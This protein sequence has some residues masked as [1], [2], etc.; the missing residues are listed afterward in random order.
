[1]ALFKSNKNKKIKLKKT[2]FSNDIQKL[3]KK[4]KTANNNYFN[5]L[6]NKLYASDITPSLVELI[7]KKLSKKISKLTDTHL[8][9]NELYSIMM[10]YYKS[11]SKKQE[12]IFNDKKL[13]VYLVIGVNGAGKTT[14]IAKIANKFKENGQKVILIAADTFRAAAVQQL[15][16]WSNKIGVS[17][18]KP[19]KPN[20]DPGSVVYE[21]LEFAKEN[22]FDLA[23]IDT[24]GRLQKKETLMKELEK[25]N[26]III[27]KN[28][29]HPEES[30]LVL[31]SNI[32]QNNLSQAKEFAKICN[33]TGIVMTKM[34]GTSKGG[35]LLSVNY[36]FGIPIKLIGFGE[37]VE[38]ISLFS[39]ED[40]LEYLIFEDEK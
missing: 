17:I 4:Y 18:F 3:A 22:N 14:S 36:N 39:I 26:K 9:N 8:I 24:A 20:Q 40:Y 2:A 33:I 10:D 11:N 34:D 5:E 30:F 15:D 25:I 13:N 32:G 37:K 38:D 12:L 29:S 23:I 31:D 19:S 16:Y 21:G 7:I 28:K 1:M 27:K 6:R 35:T